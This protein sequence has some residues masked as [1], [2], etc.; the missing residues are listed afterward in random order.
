MLEE[1]NKYMYYYRL[2]WHLSIYIMMISY[3]MIW[4]LLM[5]LLIQ[6]LE[7]NL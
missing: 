2:L 6:I 7:W 4:K 3:T 5:Y 1:D